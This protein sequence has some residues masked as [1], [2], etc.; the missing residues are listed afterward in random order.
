[1]TLSS[2]QSFFFILQLSRPGFFFSFFNGEIFT[3]LHP[4]KNF[5]EKGYF[6]TNSLIFGKA[7]IQKK[8]KNKI[9]K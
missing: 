2:N 9:K 4:K 7:F 5:L 1:M 6:V 8:S 3:I